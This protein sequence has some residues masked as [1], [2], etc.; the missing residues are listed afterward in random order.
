M[1]E[2]VPQ[3]SG[4]QQ[5][6]SQQDLSQ[7]AAAYCLDAIQLLRREAVG[8]Y[9]DVLREE[10]DEARFALTRTTFAEM[11]HSHA[12]MAKQH[13]LITFAPK[14]FLVAIGTNAVKVIG[15]TGIIQFRLLPVS[16]FSTNLQKWRT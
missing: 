1:A 14:A 13:Q 5:L 9:T 11:M 8:R 10:A 2:P 3:S 4:E 6:E 12:R 15:A 16:T 7:L